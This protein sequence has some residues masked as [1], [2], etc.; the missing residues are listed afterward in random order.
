MNE[1]TTYNGQPIDL[2]AGTYISVAKVGQQFIATDIITPQGL[3]VAG[4]TVTTTTFKKIKKIQSLLKQYLA[5]DKIATQN[6]K[7][8]RYAIVNPGTATEKQ[9]ARWNQI[10]TNALK[11]AAELGSQIET[12]KGA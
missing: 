9:I 11:R 2:N 7:K 12:L 10:G 3:Q 6:L 5:A 1:I 8:A 4:P